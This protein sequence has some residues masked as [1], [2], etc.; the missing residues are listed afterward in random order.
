MTHE[1]SEV[2]AAGSV[3]SR[4]ATRGDLPVIVAM[5]DELNELELAGCPQAP[6]IRLSL[7]EFT[8]LW[9]PSL[10]SPQ[11]CWRVVEE[12]GRPIGFGLIYLMSPPTRPPGAYL[13]WAYL[14]PGHRQH[15]T[16]RRLFEEL[17]S[18][19]RQKGAKRIELQFIEGNELARQFWTKVGFRPFAAKCVHYLDTES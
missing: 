10:D 19:A 12:D 15:G 7:D 17:A 14:Q 11:H 16:G 4:P 8:A 3:S 5:R 2:R 1:R 6:I 13:H 9:G 18:W